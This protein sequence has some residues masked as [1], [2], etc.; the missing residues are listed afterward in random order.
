MA[1]AHSRRP[2]MAG[3]E[4]SAANHRRGDSCGGQNRYEP[5]PN[6]HV[7]IPGNAAR[8][9]ENKKTPGFFNPGA[10]Y[11]LFPSVLLKADG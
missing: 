9:I 10:F 6:L 11:R 1:P 5:S 2:S 7:D 8:K 4:A 3:S